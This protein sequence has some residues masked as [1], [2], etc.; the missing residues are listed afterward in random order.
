MLY[1]LEYLVH[2][3][4]YEVLHEEFLQVMDWNARGYTCGGVGGIYIVVYRRFSPD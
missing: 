3:G 1:I 4:C 2:S